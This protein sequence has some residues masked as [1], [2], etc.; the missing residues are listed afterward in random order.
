MKK[1][2]AVYRP[3]DVISSSAVCVC[4]QKNVGFFLKSVA[5]LDTEQIWLARTSI[6]AIL[7]TSKQVF[8]LHIEINNYYKANEM[9]YA[10]TI[11]Q[12]ITQFPL[13]INNAMFCTKTWEECAIFSFYKTLH[14]KLVVTARM[15]AYYST[16]QIVRCPTR[17]TTWLILIPLKTSIMR[18]L[19]NQT[20]PLQLPFYR[21]DWFG[22]R[23]H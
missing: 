7:K 23:F 6:R 4:V 15:A 18:V 3:R 14:H 17:Y 2:A 16:K 11:I 5:K 1:D 12:S 20:C 13:Q 9:V 21:L 22:K 19:H 10:E 8:C